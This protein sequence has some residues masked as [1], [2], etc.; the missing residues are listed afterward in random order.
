MAFDGVEWNKM[1]SFLLL[2]CLE[3]WRL[4]YRRKPLI[5]EIFRFLQFDKI[6]NSL[7][8]VLYCSGFTF[9]AGAHL[10]PHPYIITVKYL[11]QL[12]LPPNAKIKSLFSQQITRSIV[13]GILVM[14]LMI[15]ISGF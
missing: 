12:F 9:V 6:Q 13:N 8:I 3:S 5:I 11:S 7:L 4:V 15:V 10:N 14:L 1:T 2:L